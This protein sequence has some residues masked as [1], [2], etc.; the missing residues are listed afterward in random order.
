MSSPRNS[1]WPGET[2]CILRTQA[3]SHWSFLGLSGSK[4]PRLK[5]SNV[6]AN[7]QKTTLDYNYFSMII[8]FIIYYPSALKRIPQLIRPMMLTGL[9]TGKYIKG[10]TGNHFSFT[11]ETARILVFI[12]S[13]ASLSISCR[14]L[15]TY[16]PI[17]NSLSVSD[18]GKDRKLRNFYS[19]RKL[20]RHGW[21]DDALLTKVVNT[22]Q[23]VVNFNYKQIDSKSIQNTSSS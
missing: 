21:C 9:R 17:P 19:L 16:Y 15:C 6:Q 18:D 14:A 13:P 12:T 2:Y 1:K 8:C 5:L 4:S 7:H 20:S 3:M 22:L 23:L 10:Q 11:A